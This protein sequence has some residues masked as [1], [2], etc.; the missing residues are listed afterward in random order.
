MTNETVKTGGT[1]RT[2]LWVVL[3]ISLAGNAVLSSAGVLLAS[4]GLGVVAL[5][6]GVALAVLHYRKR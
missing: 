3:A 5:A 2:L 4:I 1:V 6:S